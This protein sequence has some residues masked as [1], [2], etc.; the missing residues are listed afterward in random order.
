MGDRQFCSARLILGAAFALMVAI[1]VHVPAAQA[2]IEVDITKFNVDPLP[3]AISEF[4][5]TSNILG[6]E[7]ELQEMGRNMAQVISDD[8]K[9]SGLFRPLPRNAFIQRD[10][11]A[12]ARPLCDSKGA[13]NRNIQDT[14]PTVKDG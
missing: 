10:A 13:N 7:Q 12:N 6:R 5:G 14:R 9:R 4:R 8:L 2:L 11:G 1:F 3:V